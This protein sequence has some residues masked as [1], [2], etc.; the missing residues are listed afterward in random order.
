MIYLIQSENYLKIGYT[1]NVGKRL[2]QYDTYNP[3]YKLLG[4]D[5]GNEEDEKNLH[6]LCKEYL[7]KT[8]WFNYNEK[9]IEIFANYEQDP[10]HSITDKAILL[11]IN[12][13]F[14]QMIFDND[15]KKLV[16]PIIQKYNLFNLDSLIEN[17]TYNYLKNIEREITLHLDKNNVLTSYSDYIE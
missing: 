6:Y 17:E 7:Y 16:Y 10:T 9:I 15:I 14:D 8:E 2:K 13:I 1:D 5:F 12:N 4:I 11:S 3:N